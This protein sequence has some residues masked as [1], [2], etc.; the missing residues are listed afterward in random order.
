M[1]LIMDEVGTGFGRTGTMFGFEQF[2]IIPD[3]ITMAKALSGGFGPIGAVATS[4]SIAR[5]MFGKGGTSTFG[6]HALAVAAT[7]EVLTILKRKSIFLKQQKQ[8]GIML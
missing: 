2:D 3:I 8:K 5:S 7:L 4:D 1:L 6:W